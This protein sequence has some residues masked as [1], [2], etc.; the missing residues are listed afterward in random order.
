MIVESVSDARRSAHAH[1]IDRGRERDGLVDRDI[2]HALEVEDRDVAIVRRLDDERLDI[3][4]FDT[5][6]STS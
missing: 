1:G 6:T 4:P 2:Q 3:R 5:S